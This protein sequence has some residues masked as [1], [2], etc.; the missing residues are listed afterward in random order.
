[1]RSPQTPC[2][3]CCLACS[4]HSIFDGCGLL[5]WFYKALQSIL[6]HS[7]TI[8]ARTHNLLD[9]EQ[10]HPKHDYT[11]THEFFNWSC[12]LLPPQIG[13]CFHDLNLFSSY[14]SSI[15]CFSTPKIP[16][17]VGL[18]IFSW[19]IASRLYPNLHHWLLKLIWP[20]LEYEEV[21]W[22]LRLHSTRQDC[23]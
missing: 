14:L 12:D 6:T 10:H 15:L 18:Y 21:C 23:N 22:Q 17:E 9:L 3:W 13:K 20:I 7:L 1:M 5:Q 8:E 4:W 11:W 16:N 19:E 2:P